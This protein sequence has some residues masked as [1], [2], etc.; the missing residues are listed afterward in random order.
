MSASERQQSAFRSS[1]HLMQNSSQKA[2]GKY[3]LFTQAVLWSIIK[4]T[5]DERLTLNFFF[6]FAI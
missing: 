4:V 5:A 2:G 1:T 6:F 3:F